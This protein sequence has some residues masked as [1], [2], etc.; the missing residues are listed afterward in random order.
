[1]TS[2]RPTCIIINGYILG[3]GRWL[4]PHGQSIECSCTLTEQLLHICHYVNV[5]HQYDVVAP[6]V[7]SCL[8][9]VGLAM[10]QL[11]GVIPETSQYGP[12]LTGVCNPRATIGARQLSPANLQ[13]EPTKLLP[14]TTGQLASGKSKSHHKPMLNT[15]LPSNL[16]SQ[17]HGQ[18][19]TMRQKPM[20]R[21]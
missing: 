12:R 8:P 9:L 7:R 17:P 6:A 21:L 1:M 15:P 18:P 14:L 4:P 11:M 20:T 2:C 3:P 13:E 19:N 10:L 5:R 16:S